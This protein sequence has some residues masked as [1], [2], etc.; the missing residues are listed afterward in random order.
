[1]KIMFE[2]KSKSGLVVILALILHN[3]ALQQRRESFLYRS[4]SEYEAV[5]PKSMSRASSIGS[6]VGYEACS[7]LF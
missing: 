7:F 4:D 5:S 3:P 6:E 2:K 1:M